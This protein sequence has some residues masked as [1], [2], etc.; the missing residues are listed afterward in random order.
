MLAA[1]TPQQFQARAGV[2]RETLERLRAYVDLLALWNR[3]INLVGPR[4]LADVWRRHILDSAQLGRLLP[5]DAQKVVD[6]GS[7]AGLPGLVLAIIGVVEPHLVE[8]DARK[9]AFLREA[10]RITGTTIRLHA[11]RSEAV[12][13]L[14]ADVV[15]ARAFAPLPK[16]LD[17][18]EHFIDSRS[19]LL[20]L[21]GKGVRE[22]LTEAGKGW[23]MS[24]T[25]HPSVSDPSGIVLQLQQVERAGRDS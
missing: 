4:T 22:E 23:K 8:A 21:K 17:H 19:I 14:R 10:A 18:A 2:S 9:I 25:L 16:L 12:T 5:I 20:L 6:L 7:G 1:L 15:T 3:R 13:G 11:A 24:A